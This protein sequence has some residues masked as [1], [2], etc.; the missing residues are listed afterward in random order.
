MRFLHRSLCKHIF[1]EEQLEIKNLANTMFTGLVIAI[2]SHL[3]ISI[4]YVGVEHV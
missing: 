4:K 1:A 3:V 2:H